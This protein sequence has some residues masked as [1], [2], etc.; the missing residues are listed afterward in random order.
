MADYNLNLASQ[1]TQYNYNFYYQKDLNNDQSLYLNFT[2][3]DNPYHDANRKSQN[4]LSVVYKKY[5]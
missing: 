4:N 3:I 1:E 5:F 2:H